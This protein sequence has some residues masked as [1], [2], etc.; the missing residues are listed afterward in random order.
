MV[1]STLRVSL[2][3]IQDMPGALIRLCSRYVISITVNNHQFGVCDLLLSLPHHLNGRSGAAVRGKDQSRGLD[4]RK[5]A[6]D[7]NPRSSSRY[8]SA[9]LLVTAAHELRPPSNL[10]IGCL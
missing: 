10:L 6:C 4:E 1:I 2:D 5:D 3:E 7:A 9:S 8:F